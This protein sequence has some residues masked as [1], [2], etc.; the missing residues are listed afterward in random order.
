MEELRNKITEL[1]FKDKKD[2]QIIVLVLK[3]QKNDSVY[4][5]SNRLDSYIKFNEKNKQILK[6][7]RLYMIYIHRSIYIK[8][9]FNEPN[10]IGIFNEL[11][12]DRKNT[13][14]Y[15]HPFGFVEETNF[16]V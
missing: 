11:Y 7:N 2:K 15:N 13:I 14:P 9:L 6:K 1:P 4:Q 3:G 10:N 16:Y 12:T 5:I 8:D